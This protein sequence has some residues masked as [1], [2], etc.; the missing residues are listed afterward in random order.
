MDVPSAFQLRR[1][2]VAGT[3]SSLSGLA[4]AAASTIQAAPAGPRSEASLGGFGDD[5]EFVGNR[6]PDCAVDVGR[7][8]DRVQISRRLRRR[9]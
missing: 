7:K 1:L 8:I 6:R 9:V 4:G 3:D 5:E 2:T